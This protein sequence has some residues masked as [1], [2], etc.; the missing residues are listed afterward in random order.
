MAYVRIPR[1]GRS[2]ALFTNEALLDVLRAEGPVSATS[3]ARALSVKLAKIIAPHYVDQRLVFLMRKGE[4]SRKMGQ[5]TLS[6]K[7][8]WLY[9]V[10]GARTNR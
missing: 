6:N 9:Y 4:V 3:A 10:R 5:S 8:V 2:P 7:Q 1:T